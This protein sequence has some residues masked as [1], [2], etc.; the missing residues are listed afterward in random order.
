[1]LGAGT[2][3]FA[4]P[5]ALGYARHADRSGRL[6]VL[7]RVALVLAALEAVACLVF[8]AGWLWN[9]LA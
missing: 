8:A 5:F 1:V 2:T 7:G 9:R 6:P 4:T 3:G